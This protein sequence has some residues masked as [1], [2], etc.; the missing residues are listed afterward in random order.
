[1]EI[2]KSLRMDNLSEFCFEKELNFRA[3]LKKLFNEKGRSNGKSKKMLKAPK[4]EKLS[5][6]AKNLMKNPKFSSL[7]NKKNLNKIVYMMFEDY[8][9]N[10]MPM[11]ISSLVNKL[12]KTINDPNA[13][14]HMI[15]DQLLNQKFK[16][17]WSFSEFKAG[18]EIFIKFIDS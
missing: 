4:K 15:R 18:K 17:I 2:K 11:H 9:K 10:R 16:S 14:F 6:F 5:V 3:E 1:M 7:V 8:K 13:F 12:E